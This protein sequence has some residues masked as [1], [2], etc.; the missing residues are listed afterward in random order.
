[1]GDDRPANIDDF[2]AVLMRRVVE[3]RR[4]QAR[5]GVPHAAGVTRPLTPPPDEKADQMRDGRKG[6]SG[7]RKGGFMGFLARLRCW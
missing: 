3:A 4:L 6:K 5:G 1:M 7:R 2:F